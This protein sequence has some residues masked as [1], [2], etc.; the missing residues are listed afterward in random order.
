VRAATT[1]TGALTRVIG[2]DGREAVE[3]DDASEMSSEC[4]RLY[5]KH[6]EW[7]LE[8]SVAKTLTGMSDYR[9][10]TPLRSKH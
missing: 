2:E 3:T 6:G 5:L 4:S 7:M 10:G 8:T 9:V 1:E